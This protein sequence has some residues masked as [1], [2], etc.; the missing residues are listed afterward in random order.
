MEPRIILFV[1]PL[2]G[3]CAGPVIAWIGVRLPGGGGVGGRR[4]FLTAAA[5]AGVGLWAGMHHQ[6]EAMTPVT[7]GF[8]WMLLLIA[9]VDAEHF[10]LP[11]VLTL[12]LLAGGLTAAWLLAPDDLMVRGVGAA[13]G[14]AG[15]WLIGFL[16]QRVRGRQGL[17][18]GDPFLLAALGA[19]TGWAGLPSVLVWACAAAFSLIAARLILRRG[20]RGDDRLPFGPFLAIGGWMVWLYGPISV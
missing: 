2:I 10:W 19:W 5:A 3:L 9:M 7:A 17:G 18:G 6:G 1:T 8:G 15:L 4:V 16:Y 20:V 13:A 11:D 14:F 12:P